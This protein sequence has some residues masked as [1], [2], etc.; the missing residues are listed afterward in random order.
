MKNP[1]PLNPRAQRGLWLADSHAGM[2]YYVLLPDSY[3]P[4]YQYPTLLFLHAYQ[5]ESSVP[6]QANTW[7]NTAAF[8]SRHPVLIVVPVC[9]VDGQTSSPSFNWGGADPAVQK[10]IVS[11]LAILQAVVSDYSGNPN[12]LSLTGAGMGGTGTWGVLRSPAQRAQF[13]AFMPVADTCDAPPDSAAAIAEELKDVAISA[14]QSS[15]SAPGFDQAVFLVTQRLGGKMKLTTVEPDGHDI[16]DAFYA[17]M[18]NWDWL[19]AQRLR[20]AVAAP[21]RTALAIALDAFD[22]LLAQMRVDSARLRLATA[23][24]NLDALSASMT[25]ALGQL[26]SIRAALGGLPS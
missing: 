25:V 3:N 11:A 23:P 18:A 20:G 16:W 10:A 21:D 17:D 14:C 2:P 9:D 15:D 13:T 26:V 12:A 7:F 1:P 8:R 22:T 6:Q 5:T 19:F 24:A 4:D